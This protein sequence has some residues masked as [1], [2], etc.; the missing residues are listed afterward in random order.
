MASY[1]LT[2]LRLFESYFA[3]LNLTY[4]GAYDLESVHYDCDGGQS[5]EIPLCVCPTQI[6]MHMLIFPVT[7]TM[8]VAALSCF[9]KIFCPVRAYS[10]KVSQ[11]GL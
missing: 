5:V 3:C 2:I 4:K 6:V 10:S 1:C 9:L 7:V 8:A 11:F